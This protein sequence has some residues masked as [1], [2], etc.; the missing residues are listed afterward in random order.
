M[1]DNLMER[2]ARD[3][4]RIDVQEEWELKYWSG[5]LGVSEAELKQ[6]VESV[7]TYAKDV[8]SY[9]EQHRRGAHSS[10]TSRAHSRR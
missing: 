10:S 2:G 1:A 6:A 7:G 8:R 4:N 3:R 9:L 5:A